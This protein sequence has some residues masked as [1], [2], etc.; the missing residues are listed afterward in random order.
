MDFIA[1]YSRAIITM[2]VLWSF[3]QTLIPSSD[4][5]KYVRFAM[6]LVIIASM[7]SP[8]GKIKDFN[9][10]EFNFESTAKYSK[11]STN[12]LIDKIYIQKLQNEVKNKFGVSDVV[13]SIDGNRKITSVK[14]SS[15]QKEIEKY[16]GGD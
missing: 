16:L 7:I 11:A 14:A 12:S 6:G 2:V 5:K 13:I 1:N 9:M 10:P 3:M 4:M 15:R 8:I